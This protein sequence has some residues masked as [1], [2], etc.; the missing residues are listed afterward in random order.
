MAKLSFCK[1][2]PAPWLTSY[3]EL[4]SARTQPAKKHGKRAKVKETKS[5]RPDA[6]HC[7]ERNSCR[8]L[9][10]TLGPLQGDLQQLFPVLQSGISTGA[11]LGEPGQMDAHP[12][13]AAA[14]FVGRPARNLMPPGGQLG[15]A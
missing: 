14:A 8:W 4:S 12:G 10:A 2:C 13:C 5:A 1:K 11:A 6:D 3:L 9:R 7:E 15:I